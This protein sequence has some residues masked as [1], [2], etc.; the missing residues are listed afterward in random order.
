MRLS[1]YVLQEEWKT[2]RDHVSQLGTTLYA[3]H[4]SCFISLLHLLDWSVKVL[5]H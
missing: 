4:L 1:V 5:K 2:R 3:T